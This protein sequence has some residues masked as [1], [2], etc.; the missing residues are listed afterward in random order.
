MPLKMRKQF[1]VYE[2]EPAHGKD[3]NGIILAP[4][5]SKDEAEA[6]RIRYGY[7][8]DNYYVGELKN[9]R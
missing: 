6:A 7:I 5:N 4:Y 1:A 3:E 9:E 2:R 8:S